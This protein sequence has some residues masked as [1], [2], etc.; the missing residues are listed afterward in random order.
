MPYPFVG[1]VFFAI[2]DQEN[3]RFAPFASIVWTVTLPFRKRTSGNGILY[4]FI[5]NEF[6]NKYAIYSASIP[7]Y[8]Y[9]F[10][11]YLVL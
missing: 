5:M 4:K 11:F 2:V 1:K 10:G 8:F 7:V 3:R 6:L 9:F